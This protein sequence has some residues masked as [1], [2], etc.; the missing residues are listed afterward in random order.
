LGEGRVA[1][2]HLVSGN[3]SSVLGV[4]ASLGRTFL[5]EDD[6]TGNPQPVVVLGRSFWQQRLGSDP[7]VVGK[8][9]LLT[10]TSFKVIGVAPSGFAGLLVAIEPDFWA[11]ATMIEQVTRDS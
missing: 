4:N 11:P 9:L 8:S 6:Q 3:F 2:G 7:Q 10:G 1:Q 5:P